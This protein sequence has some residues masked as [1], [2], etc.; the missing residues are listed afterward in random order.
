MEHKDEF[1]EHVAQL[2]HEINRAYC[3]ALGDNSQPAWKDAPEWQRES[4]VNGVKF[5]L[6]NK[7]AD[8]ADSHHNWLKEK[9]ADGWKYGPIKDPV[10]KKHPCILHYEKLPVEQKVK[11]YLFK[12][13]VNTVH[14][15]EE[16][17]NKDY[18]ARV[19]GKL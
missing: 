14:E 8:P 7:E 6:K 3:S 18:I 5:H 13:V 15:I 16:K 9:L 2:C 1:I 4:A 11:D 10:K 12:A 19:I 17:V